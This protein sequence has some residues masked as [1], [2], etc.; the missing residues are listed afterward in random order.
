[1]SHSSSRN[2]TAPWN[3]RGR[4]CQVHREKVAKYE[5]RETIWGDKT[6]TTTKLSSQGSKPS[7]EAAASGNALLIEKISARRP[8]LAKSLYD[9]HVATPPRFNGTQTKG[10]G[11]EHRIAT[12]DTVEA[13]IDALMQIGDSEEYDSLAS[14]GASTW[15]SSLGTEATGLESA[16][17]DDKSMICGVG[18]EKLKTKTK[19]KTKNGSVGAWEEADPDERRAWENMKRRVMHIEEFGA[20]PLDGA[21]GARDAERTSRDFRARRRRSWAEKAMRVGGHAREETSRRAAKKW[22]RNAGCWVREDGVFM[23]LVRG[24]TSF[25][26]FLICIHGL[27]RS[28]FFLTRFYSTHVECEAYQAFGLGP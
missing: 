15:T 22:R 1:M 3:V 21:G 19:T 28:F 20:L 13:L 6:T 2:T 27:T 14:L 7:S 17:I 4:S 26:F 10:E 5:G 16:A 18:E 24:E 11:A 12:G 25:P 9:D 8:E 23:R